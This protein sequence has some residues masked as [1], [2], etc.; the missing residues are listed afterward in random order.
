[1]PPRRQ[2]SRTSR[3]E[4]AER[5]S[6]AET[7]AGLASSIEH[8]SFFPHDG[9]AHWNSCDDRAA[10]DFARLPSMVIEE[11]NVSAVLQNSQ[12]LP[13]PAHN[14]SVDGIVDT[15]DHGRVKVPSRKLKSQ[16][17]RQRVHVQS[18]PSVCSANVIH[19]GQSSS[20]VHTPAMSENVVF[21]D[22]NHQNAVNAGYSVSM[23][24]TG[25]AVLSA[26]MVGW[27]PPV[28]AS[29][30]GNNIE[31]ASPDEV[32][33]PLSMLRTVDPANN[34]SG[35]LKLPLVLEQASDGTWQLV[36]VSATPAFCSALLPSMGCVVQTVVQQSEEPPCSRDRTGSQPVSSNMAVGTGS[37]VSTAVSNTQHQLHSVGSVSVPGSCY[38]GPV[39]VTGSGSCSDRTTDKPSV[40]SV[41]SNDASSNEA[42]VSGSSGLGSLSALRDFYKRIS[43]NI[44]QSTS[45]TAADIQMLNSTEHVACVES[46]MISCSSLKLPAVSA[47]VYNDQVVQPVPCINAVSS[48]R[49]VDVG[50]VLPAVS[51]DHRRTLSSDSR[52]Q[53]LLAE[54]HCNLHRE[55][56]LASPLF[57]DG[58]H[59][60][61]LAEHPC[62]FLQH[63]PPKK[64]QKVSN[65]IHCETR[66]NG[67]QH[68]TLD[69][70]HSKQTVNDS[71][72][73]PDIL[74]NE[75]V[76]IHT[77]RPSSANVAVSGALLCQL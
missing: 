34:S 46:N 65:D 14:V 73:P 72:N 9:T 26:V 56:T 60:Q 54:S 37:L 35:I 62:K 10:A 1:M 52:N 2:R 36:P 74:L 13:L 41:P 15:A 68:R 40:T 17:G 38:N 18:Q 31:P 55:A 71:D 59:E 63:L 24:F 61:S 4:T 43:T 25:D 51:V 7:I 22:M 29:C 57:T 66:Q 28:L 3:K 8:P 33:S 64:R 21:R 49:N 75:E 77:E 23:P 6:I 70:L 50:R 69:D 44:V 16:A 42:A 67:F 12:S 20:T 58:G 48:V 27:N 30:P 39:T 5:L 11:L 47:S 19:H 45:W 32:S 76:I 53:L